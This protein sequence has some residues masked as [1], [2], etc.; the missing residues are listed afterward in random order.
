MK[1]RTLLEVVLCSIIGAVIGSLVASYV[2]KKRWFNHEA[3]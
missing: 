1:K 3:A 2:E